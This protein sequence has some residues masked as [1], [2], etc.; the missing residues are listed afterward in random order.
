MLSKELQIDV[1]IVA[2][3]YF[4]LG[5]QLGFEW[6]RKTAL[7]L[8]GETHWSQ[9]AANALIEDFYTNQRAMTKKILT[10]GPSLSHLFKLDGT[11]AENVLH[12]V[13]IES[14]IVD[15]MN[16]ATVDFAMMTVINRRLHMLA[17]GG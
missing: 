7:G 5:Q 14:I 8:S 16:A 15:V 1:K 12:T 11:M 17:H 6:L 2:K 3:V 10:S 9:E 4:A 13:D